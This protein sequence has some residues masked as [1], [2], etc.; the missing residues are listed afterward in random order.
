MLINPYTLTPI[1]ERTTHRMSV[2]KL[3]RFMEFEPLLRECGWQLTCPQCAVKFGYGK[4]G[5]RGDNDPQS[6]TYTVECGCSV[7]IFDAR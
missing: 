3:K 7:H 1:A 2:D 6:N 4:D 5:V